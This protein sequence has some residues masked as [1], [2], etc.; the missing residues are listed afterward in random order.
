MSVVTEVPGSAHVA[1]EPFSLL[2]TSGLFARIESRLGF[3][4]RLHPLAQQ[5]ARVASYLFITWAAPMVLASVE[6]ARSGALSF[7]ADFET[8]LRS[9]VAI[10]LLLFAES[11]VD[12]EVRYVVR[13]LASPRR[14]RRPEEL[15]AR[16]RSLRPL[17]KHPLVGALLLALA[18]LIV[19]TWIRHHTSG[20][21]TWIFVKGAKPMLTAA[22][23]WQA[24]VVVPVYIF[25]LLRWIWRWVVLALVFARSAP[26][27]RPIVSHGDRCG[28]FSFVSH[29]PA[30]FAW[31]IA[32]VSSLVSARWLFAI[33]REGV[34]ASA[35]TKQMLAIAILSVGLAFFPLLGFTLHFAR[36]KRSGLRRY[37]AV[38]EGH[39]RNIERQWYRRPYP[40]H[41][42]SEESSSLTDLNSIYDVVRTMQIFPYRR[43]HLF[44][45][46]LAAIGPMLPV[47]SLIAPSKEILRQV[48]QA[49]L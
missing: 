38:V 7:M 41:V 44:V 11:R 12:P 37:R 8:H 25:L 22:G 4:P 1:E 16:I 14:C 28:G 39:A 5:G 15:R 18:F 3:D 40:A 27:L 29:A 35:V 9:L 30:R 6:P 21:E 31:V 48:F 20:R 34:P 36:A 13:S 17:I 43:A 23:T 42:A 49:L 26:L 10:P 46:A 24:Y 19:P 2:T 32:G 47:L 33:V 45:V